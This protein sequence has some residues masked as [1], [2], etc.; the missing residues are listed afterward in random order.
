M[1]TTVDNKDLRVDEARVARA[2]NGTPGCMC[3]CLG[4]YAERDE[5]GMALLRR[6]VTNLNREIETRTWVAVTSTG[7]ENHLRSTGDDANLFM[8]SEYTCFE[9]GRGVLAAYFA[10]VAAPAGR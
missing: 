8:T 3:G 2:Y 1:E 6:R 4:T 9:T 10:E 7:G 5:A